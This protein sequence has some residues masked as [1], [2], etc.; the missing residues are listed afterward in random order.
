VDSAADK[1][2]AYKYPDDATVMYLYESYSKIVKASEGVKNEHFIVWMRTAGLP[3]F[4]KLY[5]K[6]STDL[7][8]GDVVSFSVNNNFNV[9][10]FSGKKSLVISTVSWFGG[11]NPFLGQS[12][13]VVGAICIALAVVFGVKHM[14]S[15]RKLGDT[16]YLV[17]K[18]A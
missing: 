12:Y 7:K 14:V 9:D 13:I 18:D 6:I 2:L 11:K 5:G 17:W 10:S 8:K 3:T 16:K 15:P 1:C 4:R